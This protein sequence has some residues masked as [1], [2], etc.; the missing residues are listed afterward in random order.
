ML[1]RVIHE[2]AYD[3]APPVKTAQHMAHLKPASNERQR[4]LSHALAITPT[5]AQ[6][7]ETIDV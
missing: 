6:Q 5:P 7:G 3:Y 4:L 2:T 1:L